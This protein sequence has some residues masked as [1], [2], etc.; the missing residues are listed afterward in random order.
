M[1]ISDILKA[2]ATL[3]AREDVVEYLSQ[4]EEGEASKNTLE[5]V[6][7]LTRLTNIVIREL[8]NGLIVMKKR[9]FVKARDSVTFSELEIAPLDVIAVYD[10]KGN[11]LDYKL[12]PYGLTVTNGL[13]NEIEYYYMPENY[14]LTDTVGDFEKPVT[15]GTLAYGVSAEFCLTEARFDEAIMWNDRYVNSVNALIRP[16]NGKMRGRSFV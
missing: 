16:K 6:D 5:T 10:K 3:L 9:A 4:S 7:L 14:G 8:C 2:T 1:K 12:S 11:K 15:V 13:I